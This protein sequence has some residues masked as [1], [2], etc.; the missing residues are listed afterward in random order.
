MKD[1]TLRPFWIGFVVTAVA[2]AV[3]LY[4]SR[5]QQ[6]MQAPGVL[7]LDGSPGAEP[8]PVTVPGA[9]AERMVSSSTTAAPDTGRRR[10]QL[11]AIKGIGAV[12]ASRL[13]AAGINTYEELAAADPA[14]VAEIVGLRSWQAANPQTWI[15]AARELAGQ[16]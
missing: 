13:Y 4:W 7:L 8:D 16:K 3:Y 2:V 5:Q 6:R 11:D 1:K 9:V 10:D 14:R 12:Y 15:A